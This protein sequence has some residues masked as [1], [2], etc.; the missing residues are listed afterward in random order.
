[1]SCYDKYSTIYASAF[2][3]VCFA[4][5]FGPQTNLSQKFIV[6]DANFLT[7]LMDYISLGTHKAMLFGLGKVM[8][9]VEVRKDAPK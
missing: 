8:S 4:R 9:C 2:H 7:E 6:I 5:F 3:K 1:M